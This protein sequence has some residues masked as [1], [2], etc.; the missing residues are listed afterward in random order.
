MYVEYD[1][2]NSGGS[3]W[4]SDEDWKKL[5]EAG[6]VVDWARLENLYTDEGG[7]VRDE[8]TGLP[9]LVPVGQGNSKYGGS[10]VSKGDDGEYRYLGALA[11]K[12][13]KLDAASLRE[14]ANEW[15]DITGQSA[16]DAGCACCGQPHN[17]TL[18]DD[19]HKYVESG[20]EAEY[21]ASW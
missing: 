4:L 19:N 14:A 1:S 7:Y 12:A 16:L 15:E 13:W 10:W 2:N 9:K 6:W 8:E 18:Y 3:W 11:R 5:E 20:P 17:F 21:S